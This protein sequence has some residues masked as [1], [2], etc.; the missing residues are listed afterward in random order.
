MIFE[1]QQV[2]TNFNMVWMAEQAKKSIATAICP[3]EKGQLNIVID[4][5]DKDRFSLTYNPN[6]GSLG[7]SLLDRLSFK[8]IHSENVV[9]SIVGKNQKV[10]GFLQSYPYRVMNFQDINYY[11]YEVV[12]GNDGL[13]L[14][15]YKDDQLIAI[16]EKDLKVVNFQDHYTVYALN[17]DDL[18]IIMPLIMHYDITA[19][20]DMMEIAVRSVKKKKVN[21]IQKELIAKFDSAFIA[22][23]KQRDGVVD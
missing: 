9:G 22:A 20:G 2:K 13:Y 8:L 1:I 7:T 21:T 12:F 11:L 3:F 23:I 14:C 5:F 15:I 4:Y 17:E 16:S 19:H 18:K 10:K 6:D